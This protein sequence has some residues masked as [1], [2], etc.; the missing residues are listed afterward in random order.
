MIIYGGSIKE[1]INKGMKIYKCEANDLRIHTI[2][3]PRLVLF[4][5]IKKEGKYRVELA[6]A[7]RKEACQDKNKDSCVDGYIEIVSGKAMVADP[8]GDGYY[9]AIDPANPN[10]DIYLNGNKINSV[11]VV[12]QKDTI[13][14]R[15]VVREAVTEVNAQLSRDKMKAILTVTKTPGKQYYL[16]DA[17]K[18]RL[19]KVSLGC[20]ETPAP[21][22]TME[23]CIQELEKIKV[24]LKFI[25]KNAIKKLLEQPD[26]GSAVVAEGIYPIDGRAS[27]VK[28]LFESNKIRN[29]AFE[30]DDKVDL[31][32]H[33]I[34]PT[35]EVGQ[36]LAVKE[37]LA[38]PGRDG[39]TVTGETVKA[40]P[41]KETPFRAGKGT[42]LLDRDT[43]IVASCSGRPMLRN[44][45][46]SVLPLLVIPGDVNPET[47]NINFNGDVH[48]K[49]S[50]MDNLKVIADGDIIVSGNVLQANLIAKGSIDIAGNIIS[51]K[52]TAGTA[53]I[54]NLCILPII[55]Q[56]LDIVNNDFFDANSEVWLSGYRK[57]MERHPVMYSE[58]RQRIEGL[59]KDMKCM[60]RLLP[61]ED[62]VLIKGILEEISIIYAAGN[63][64][65]A[66]QIKRLKGR[67]QEYLANTLS[68]EGG[69]ADIRL[70]YAQNSIIQAS[71][72]ILVLGRGTYQTDIIA[73]EVIRFMKPSSVVLGGTLIA[74]KRMSMGIVGSPYGITTHCK[75]LDK[76]GKIDAVR[77][78]SNTVITV[79]NKRKIV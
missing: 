64:V 55:K 42:M 29:P 73:E 12:T 46:V 56:V 52:I 23:Q 31:L 58:R 71:G 63:L 72:D 4:G 10:V 57:M 22:V 9:A 60:A 40:K 38:I 50:V 44:G 7:K 15:P 18:T 48:I 8:V 32:D 54:N 11:S 59:V 62:Y 30:T 19:L 24:A 43:K 41:V 66:G 74:G 14:L 20:K 76:N 77:L 45:M 34:L 35:V 13:E 27:R 16:E 65:N 37:I 17:P 39:E 70:R 5:L 49:G 6:R 67:I 69:D 28:Y 75:V 21:D 78:Y 2:K 53:V 3:E 1:A 47:G 79:N 36:V 33:T 51:S 26:G 61:D 25:D 68:A